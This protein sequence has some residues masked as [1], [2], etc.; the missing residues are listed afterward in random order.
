MPTS[1]LKKITTRAKEIYKKGGTW[2]GAIKKAGA[3]YRSGKVA[4]VI[5]MKR[6]KRKVSGTLSGQGSSAISG[7]RKRRIVRKKS[8]SRR[9]TIG[10]VAS[11][12]SKA[13]K[14]IA[15]KIGIAETQKFK[16]PKKMQKRKIAKRI[17]KLKTQ[18]RKLC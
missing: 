4:K 7:M 11:H 15:D 6:K 16:A 1:T 9:R 10:T 8:V 14:M 12:V 13:K 5:H 18:F 3:E 2:K 17:S